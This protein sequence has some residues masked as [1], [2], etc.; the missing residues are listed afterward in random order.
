MMAIQ[1]GA[2]VANKTVVSN[3]HVVRAVHLN[4]QWARHLFKKKRE[5]KKKSVLLFRA[6]SLKEMPISVSQSNDSDVMSLLG[7]P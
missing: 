7:Q 5:K 3:A 1:R 6:T 4:W 2:K